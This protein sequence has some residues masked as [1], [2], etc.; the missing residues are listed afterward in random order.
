MTK[1]MFQLIREY[2]EGVINRKSFCYL[3]GK[4]R[5]IITAIT[6]IT[7]ELNGF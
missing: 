6:E 3:W 1:R 5:E 7:R 4:E 2:R